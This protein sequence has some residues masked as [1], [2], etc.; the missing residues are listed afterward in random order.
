MPMF[1]GMGYPLVPG[2]ESVGTVSASAGAARH[3]RLAQRSSCRVRTVTA[4]KCA[5]SSAVP[6]ARVV[7]P[8]SRVIPW[9]PHSASAPRCS[10]S[11]PRR[12]TRCAAAPS[13]PT[14][15]LATASLADSPHA[16]RGAR[17]LAH[18]V[19]AQPERMSG[20]TDYAVCLS[21]DDARRDYRC[22]FDASGDAALHRYAG[23]APREGGRDRARR[24]LLDADLVRLPAGLHEGGAL[25]HCRRVV[26]ER[27]RGRASRCTRWASSRSMVSSRISPPPTAL[28]MPTAPRSKIRAVSRW[29]STGAHSRDSLRNATGDALVQLHRNLRDEATAEPTPVPP[30][31]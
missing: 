13:F 17:R 10:H 31:R 16:S 28:R 4:V 6:R 20:A 27:S 21:D 29:S 7:V 15:S 2:Y 12:C 8:A 26:A 19:G 3:S 9:T 18:G 24:L 30:A 23:D 1:P 11:A 14:S 25:A 5:D 22:I